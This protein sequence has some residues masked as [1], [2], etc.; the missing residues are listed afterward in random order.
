MSEHVVINEV[1]P[2]DGLQSQARHL[3]VAQRLA[4][5][6]ALAGCGLRSIEAGSFVSPKAVPQMAGTGDLFPRLP[7]SGR[8]RYSA[9]IPNARGYELA[10]AAGVRTVSVVLSAT[11]TMNRRN[12]G[13]SLEETVG[14][15]TE[16]MR[17]AAEDGVDGWA[18]LAVAYACP[19]E[20]N[21]PVDRVL[22]LADAMLAAG[23]RKL[24][25]ADTIGA[26]DPARVK[27]LI[28]ALVARAGAA[29]IGCHFH[30]TRG[31]ALANV[32]A[33]L[34]CG[35]RDFDS[36]IGG[37]GGCPFSPGASGNVAT[38]DV[39]LMLESMGLDTG[40]SL[41]ALTATVRKASALL[42]APLGG[43]A[44]RWLDRTYPSSREGDHA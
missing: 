4:M 20:G 38:E 41:P 39:I 24:I 6:Q 27:A 9:L 40:V 23:A 5:I 42:D 3:D 7:D 37:L 10:R 13:M 14:A 8:I 15:C 25:V 2:R 31:M 44:F 32:L 18:Y 12:I 17:R 21:T 30:D 35:V 22:A 36:A 11:E 28:G 34:E 29:R 1:G 33:A 26:A 16:L 19:F 43:H